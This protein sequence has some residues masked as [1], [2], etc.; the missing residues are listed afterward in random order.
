MAR[1]RSQGKR[2]T[3]QKQHLHDVNKENVSPTTGSRRT[4]PHPK[5]NPK[6]PAQTPTQPF[7]EIKNKLANCQRKVRHLQ[8]KGKEARESIKE[9]KRKGVEG[10]KKIL[11]LQ[12]ERD[13]MEKGKVA[14][15]A[16]LAEE[17]KRSDREAEKRPETFDGDWSVQI[18]SEKVLSGVLNRR[19]RWSS[20]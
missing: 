15:E 9:L 14:V 2:S 5:S 12:R 4:V 13:I 3:L 10:L 1:I 11:L 6:A 20:S 16:A 18:K 19:H 17:P 8:K 7:A